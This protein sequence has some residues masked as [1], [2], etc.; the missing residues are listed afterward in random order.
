[1]FRTLTLA[2]ALSLMAAAA[3][4]E[5]VYFGD[6]DTASPAGAKTL[7]SRVQTAAESACSAWKQDANRS[8]FYAA[9]YQGCISTASHQA[10]SQAMSF[11]RASDRVAS[12]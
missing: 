5:T 6:L 4:A 2:A 3:Q 10:I 1:M 7:A 8:M 11:N 9:T 12:K